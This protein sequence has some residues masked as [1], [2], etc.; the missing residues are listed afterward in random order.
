MKFLSK[1]ILASTFL[2]SPAWA[3]QHGTDTDVGFETPGVTLPKLLKGDITDIPSL[4]KT[5]VSFLQTIAIPILAIM[6]IWGAFQMMF[7]AGNP[8]NFKKGQKT[9]IW[10]VIGFAIILIANG[11]AAIVERL[12]K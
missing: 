5:I 8:E 1:I 7:A 2:A 11:I 10:A 9:I 12:L 4:L 3:K 6:V